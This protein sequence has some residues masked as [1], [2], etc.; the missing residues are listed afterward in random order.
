ME[1][2]DY[3]KALG[4]ERGADQKTISRAF[5]RLARESHP[6]VNKRKGAEDRF[7]EINEANQVLGDP[8]KRAQYD[9]IY[10]AYKNGGVSWQDLVGRGAG[11]RT[12]WT[13]PG[14]FT[15]TVGGEEDV[16]EIFGRSGGVSDF[17]Q[18]LFGGVAGF[19]RQAAEPQAP[20]RLESAVEITLED[21]CRGG[22]RRVELPRS[23]RRIEVEIPRGVR[24]GQTIRLAGAA[25]GQDVYLTLRISPHRLFERTDDDLTVEVP[26]SIT[27]AALGA[28]VDVP[29]LDG[30]VTMTVPPETQTGRLFRLKGLG[31][32]HAVSRGSREPSRGDLYVRVRVVVPTGLSKRERE[33]FEE[34]RQARA[35]D[36]RRGLFS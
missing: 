5:R 2:K 14:G 8:A 25:D 29:T 1:F 21:A 15:V 17:F 9:Q 33:L 28:Q 35:D 3:Y 16:E 26:V 12:G 11:R 36:P 27:E 30:K 24:E 6:D 31:M 19:G 4:V 32:P 23:R 34:L 18:Q 13:G 22:K 20:P 7:K 10:E